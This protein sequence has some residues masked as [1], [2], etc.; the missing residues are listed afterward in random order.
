MITDFAA[1]FIPGSES[2]TTVHDKISNSN[3]SIEKLDLI[4]VDP[5]IDI[6]SLGIIVYTLMAKQ[7]PCNQILVSKSGEEIK[8]N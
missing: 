4:D 6:F 7:E 2:A 8:E 1:S 5:S 3:A